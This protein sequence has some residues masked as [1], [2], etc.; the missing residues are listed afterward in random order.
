[1]LV[2]VHL[3]FIALP[4]LLLSLLHVPT[5]TYL[6]TLAAIARTRLVVG[7]PS[8]ATFAPNE[9]STHSALQRR[10]SSSSSLLSLL[11]S[12]A[13]SSARHHTHTHTHT[14]THAPLSLSL[15]IVDWPDVVQCSGRPGHFASSSNLIPG[16][17]C[18]RQLPPPP[19]VPPDRPG[20]AQ[21]PT[22]CAQLLSL[23]ASTVAAPPGP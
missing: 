10:S 16:L 23:V 19:E 18:C 13:P 22:H 4:F 15:H 7:A 14:H 20:A 21:F 17:R 1:M 9:A 11:Q 5:Y 6:P 12:A 3:L 8:P 2:D